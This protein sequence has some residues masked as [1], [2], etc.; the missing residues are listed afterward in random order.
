MYTDPSAAS[1]ATRSNLP[2]DA[3]NTAASPTPVTAREQDAITLWMAECVRA[4]GLIDTN[5]TLFTALGAVRPVL[6]RLAVTSPEQGV[7]AEVLA[8]VERALALDTA[9][10]AGAGAP[11]SRGTDAR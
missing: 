1:A 4:N 3:G 6:R 8:E 7:V 5:R 11:P 10:A 9:D 2:S